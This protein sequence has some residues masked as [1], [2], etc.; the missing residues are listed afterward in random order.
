MKSLKFSLFLALLVF[1][2]TGYG[3]TP[4]PYLET[5]MLNEV[6]C[7]IK[8]KTSVHFDKSLSQVIN[9][10]IG[11]LPK[12]HPLWTD[13]MGQNDILVL[14]TKFDRSS[15]KSYY[16][17]SS[18]GPSCDPAFYFYDEAEDQYIRGAVG[19]HIYIPGSGKIYSSGHYNAPFD[20]H[21]KYVFNGEKFTEVKPE[22]YSVGLKT[23][24]TLPVTLF[25]DRDMTKEIAS[26]PKGYNVEVLLGKSVKTYGTEWDFLIKTEFGILGW[27]RI[28]TYALAE[29]GIAGIFWNGD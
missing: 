15:A 26:L 5:L 3:Q 21:R 27:L 18:N 7:G 16:L 9:K 12:D 14:E 24:T 23:K 6:G 8:D 17:I 19:S 13:E 25:A 22:F 28:Q 2:S 10:R 29:I 4:F 20:I 11:D 1:G